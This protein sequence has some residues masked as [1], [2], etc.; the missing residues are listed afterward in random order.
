MEFLRLPSPDNAVATL[1]NFAMEQ[2]GSSLDGVILS[3]AVFQ[4]ERRI[5]RLIDV[6]RQPNCTTERLRI[7]LLTK[8]EH[9]E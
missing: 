4:A 8:R 3:A 1:E 2:V 9:S 5:S 7:E 6:E